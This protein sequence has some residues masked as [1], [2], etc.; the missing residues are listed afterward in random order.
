MK[1]N[2]FG[3]LNDLCSECNVSNCC[4]SNVRENFDVFNN[5]L[6]ISESVDQVQLSLNISSSQFD[7]SIVY[8]DI[9]DSSVTYSTTSDVES[10]IVLNE[11]MRPSNEVMVDMPLEG[12]SLHSNI[13]FSAS[14]S[15]VNVSSSNTFSSIASTN[16]N[17][18][19]ETSL[20]DNDQTDTCSLN[21]LGF[22]CKG[23]RIGHI[24]IQ[25][26]NNKIDQV[27]FMLSSEKN[28]IQIFGLSET[29][30]QN[31]HPDNIYEINGYQKPFRR[32][33][34]KNQGGGIL[35]YV[36]NGVACKHRP[37]LEHKQLESIWLEVKPKKS[38]PFLV[39][40]I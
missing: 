24:N 29:K 7:D 17:S 13:S 4:C 39:G 5:D 19:N 9:F 40:H 35:L 8:N 30:L 26:L 38:K 10:N 20:I 15:D 6:T 31:F 32:D 37:D 25:G 14:H 18:S 12:M 28:R 33:R 21:D 22:T 27:R 11:S 23:F 2:R 1:N 16:N 36:E 3:L 34:Q